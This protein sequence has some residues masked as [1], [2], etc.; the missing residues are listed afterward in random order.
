MRTVIMG[1]A[2]E[3]G[4][5]LTRD[6]ARS[7]AFDELVIADVDEAGARALAD[8]L[9]RGGVTAVGLDVHDREAALRLLEGADV[10]MNCTSF[11][12]F[13]AVLDL[14]IESR[15]DYADL[16]SEPT[17]AQARAVRDAGITAISGLG[18]TPG[19]S[20]V[21]VR[22]AAEELD[23]LEEV[24][25]SWVSFRTIAPTP[26]LLDT[27]LWEVSEDCET[28]QFFQNGRY[29]RAAF[30]D[31]SRLVR[32]AEPVGPQRV[33]FLPHPEVRTLPRHFPSLRFCAVR[34]SWRPELMEDMRVLSRYGLLAGD[35]RETTKQ[36]IWDRLGGRR[37]DAPWMLFVHVEVVAMHDGE[38]VRRAYDASHPATWGQLGPGRMTGVPAS[39]GAQLL[40]RHGRIETGFVDPEVYYD[41]FEFLAELERRGTVRVTWSQEA[42]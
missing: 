1:G 12:L 34:G 30:L 22:H 37:D 40:A 42:V 41:P 20:N 27:I 38:R 11:V 3:V 23:E 18:A 19:L 39:V 29:E 36:S 9:G 16:I 5:E 17:Q 35:R 8:E 2:G 28:R 14:A 24:H 4:G 13:D 15:V 6:L 21:L 31:G 7:G 10:L 33:T 26:G 32:F 25:I